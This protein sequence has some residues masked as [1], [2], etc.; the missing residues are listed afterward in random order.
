MKVKVVKR[1]GIILAQVQHWEECSQ[2]A[3]WT[4]TIILIVIS[5]GSLT[6]LLITKNP[7]KKE[8]KK[9]KGTKKYKKEKRTR[10]NVKKKTNSHKN[11]EKRNKKIRLP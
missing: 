3:L 6:S 8:T 9:N 5:H 10:A 2:R 7:N 4:D 11:E 1:D